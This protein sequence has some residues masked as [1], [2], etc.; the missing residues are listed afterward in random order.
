MPTLE[1]QD[2]RLLLSQDGGFS[3][4]CTPLE[5]ASHVGWIDCSGMDDEAFQRLISERMYASARLV[6]VTVH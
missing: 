6:G 2:C 3:A 1:P 4:W 5:V